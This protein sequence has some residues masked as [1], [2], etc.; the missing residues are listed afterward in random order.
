MENGGEPSINQASF[1]QAGFQMYRIHQVM[2]QINL[3]WTNLTGETEGTPNHLVL[4]NCLCA[5]YLEVQNSFSPEEVKQLDDNLNL[6]EEVINNN[7]IWSS[8]VSNGLSGNKRS[9]T[10]NLAYYNILRKDLRNFQALILKYAGK[11][12]LLN[13]NKAD[14]RRSVIEN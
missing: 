2:S 6:L 13:P 7:S 1:N 3:C 10:L 11:H 5:Y 8:S 4:F 9:T 12:G 14:A